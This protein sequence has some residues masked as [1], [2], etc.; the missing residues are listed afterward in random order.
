MPRDKALCDDPGLDIAE[1]LMF[2]GPKG[3]RKEAVA[4]TQEYNHVEFVIL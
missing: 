2:S 3:L 4:R 1:V